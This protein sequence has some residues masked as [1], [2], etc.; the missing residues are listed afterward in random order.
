MAKFVY[1][2]QNLLNL[3]EKLEEQ[4]KAAFGMAKAKLDAEEQK[5][6]ELYGKKEYYQEALVNCFSSKLDLLSIKKNEDALK[7]VQIKIEQQIIMV[8]Q[9]E[10]QL[11][12][13][14]IQ[15][16]EAMKERKTHEKLREKAFETFKSELIQE[17]NKETDELV[18]FKYGIAKGE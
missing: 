8:K 15:L 12:I 3:K 4:Q 9:A 5:L 18:S 13:A 6:A 1:G 10:R 7:V 14:R 16:T 11:E 2:M 17:E